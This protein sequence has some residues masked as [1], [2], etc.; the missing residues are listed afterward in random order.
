MKN[1]SSNKIEEEA[2]TP[3]SLDYI[4]TVQQRMKQDDSKPI[5]F[6]HIL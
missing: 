1:T 4:K 5:F 6:N 3:I 2:E